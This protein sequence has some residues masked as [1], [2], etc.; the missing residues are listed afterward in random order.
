MHTHMHTIN[1]AHGTY[2]Q[3]SEMIKGEV[4]SDYI[5]PGV[6]EGTEFFDTVMAHGDAT[7]LLQQI[8]WFW[9]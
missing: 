4:K 5:L 2:M 1:T 9:Y 6:Y 3:R 7:K 8:Y